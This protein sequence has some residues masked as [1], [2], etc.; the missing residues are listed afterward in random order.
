MTMIEVA[1]NA[2]GEASISTPGPT[3]VVRLGRAGV[4][5]GLLL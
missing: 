1:K 3:L 2:S 4:A 5:L